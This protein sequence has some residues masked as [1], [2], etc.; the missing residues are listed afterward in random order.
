[1]LKPDPFVHRGDAASPHPSQGGDLRIDEVAL[2]GGGWVGMCHFPGRQGTDSQGRIWQRRVQDDLEVIARWGATAVV[3]LVETSEFDT[4]GVPD[5]GQRV[6]SLGLAWYHLPIVDMG[7]PAQ[8]PWASTHGSGAAVMQHLRRGERVVF[9]C[10]AGL[11]RT[12]TLAAAALVALGLEPQAAIDRV[13][14]VRPGTLETAMQ[15]DFVR[16]LA[17]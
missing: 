13:R 9:H 1:M 5:L 12:G 11:G 2:P 10:A 16:A 15:E 7:V 17:P 8:L 3:S 6:Q 14:Q 4:Y